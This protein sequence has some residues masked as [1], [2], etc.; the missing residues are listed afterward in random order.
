MPAE[1]KLEREFRPTG[2]W[3]TVIKVWAVETSHGRQTSLPHDW[4]FEVVAEWT[5]PP[6]VGFPPSPTPVSARDVLIVESRDEAIW[7]ARRAWYAFAK[8]GDQPPDLRDFITRNSV[9]F[10]PRP[11]NGAI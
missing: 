7:L 4:L 3:A 10:V 5:G 11:E 9:A 1:R 2:P 6:A 8:G